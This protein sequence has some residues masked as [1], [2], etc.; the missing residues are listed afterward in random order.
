MNGDDLIPFSWLEYRHQWLNLRGKFQTVSDL[1]QSWRC[2]SGG[3]PLWFQSLLDG[4][5]W[6]DVQ[7]FMSPRWIQM[8]PAVWGDPSFFPPADRE[9]SAILID[10]HEIWTTRH[11]RSSLNELC[12][13]CWTGAIHLLPWGVCMFSGFSDFLPQSKNMHKVSLMGSPKLSVGVNGCLSAICQPYNELATYPGCSI[14]KSPPPT[15]KRISCHRQWMDSK[16]FSQLDK[17]LLLFS[18]V[19]SARVWFPSRLCCWWWRSPAVDLWWINGSSN[20][21]PSV[22]QCFVLKECS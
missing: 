18:Q 3:P 1:L 2:R 15:L 21:R 7:I 10:C 12:S 17:K 13:L 5:P 4:L 11:S 22:K 9:T 16:W 6:S 8:F 14:P 19:A 20:H